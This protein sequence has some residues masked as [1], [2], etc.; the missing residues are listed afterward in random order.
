MIIKFD[1]ICTIWEIVNLI[2]VSKD[3]LVLCITAV[4][5]LKQLLSFL[6]MSLFNNKASTVLHTSSNFGCILLLFTNLDQKQY[7]LIQMPIPWPLNQ[8]SNLMFLQPYSRKCWHQSCCFFFSSD[9][10][11]IFFSPFLVLFIFSF[12][13]I[14]LIENNLS[15]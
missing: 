6:L 1:W 13:M 14:R 3:Q 7:L 5:M 15:F 10:L 9:F 2:I 4:K 11:Y 12:S 8:L